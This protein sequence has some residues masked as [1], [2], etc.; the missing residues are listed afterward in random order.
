MTK[1]NYLSEVSDNINGNYETRNT[2]Q[3]PGQVV[4]CSW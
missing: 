2:I 4:C 1:R 3:Y